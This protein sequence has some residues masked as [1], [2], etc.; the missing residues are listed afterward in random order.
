[1]TTPFEIIGKR[2]VPDVPKGHQRNQREALCFFDDTDVAPILRKKVKPKVDRKEPDP[3][4]VVPPK[5]DKPKDDK[6][7]DDRDVPPILRK[8]AGPKGT[9]KGPESGKGKVEKKEEKIGA[10]KEEKKEERKEE[11]KE[12]RKGK[13]EKK[14][15]D[16]TKLDT[17]EATKAFIKKVE[18]DTEKKPKQENWNFDVPTS[19]VDAA[20]VSRYF[21]ERGWEATVS[22][23]KSSSERV[24]LLAKPAPLVVYPPLEPADE[25]ALFKNELPGGV[26]KRVEETTEPVLAA[27]RPRIDQMF[28]RHN[29]NLLKENAPWSM[30]GSA[31]SA[32]LVHPVVRGGFDI[33]HHRSAP[34]SRLHRVSQYWLE[35]THVTSLDQHGPLRWLF[36]K[37][38]ESLKQ[39]SADLV[40]KDEAT[41]QA[42]LTKKNGSGLQGAD[43]TDFQ[44]LETRRSICNWD[45]WKTPTGARQQLLLA[46]ANAALF[47][48][49]ELA[50][51]QQRA[52]AL[53]DLHNQYPGLSPDF[54]LTSLTEQVREFDQQHQAVRDTL[55]SHY[56][57]RGA[58][59]KKLTNP[60]PRQT[61]ELTWIRKHL[62]LLDVD[63]TSGEWS[64]VNTA[65]DRLDRI[66][67]HRRTGQR[68]HPRCVHAQEEQILSSR[69]EA[70]ENLTDPAGLTSIPA[71][72]ARTVGDLE[73]YTRLT[74]RMFQGDQDALR[75][76][77]A[78]GR[79]N[80]T[81]GDQWELD[82]LQA[83]RD[84]LEPRL[85]QTAEDAK[86]QLK[87]AKRLKKASDASKNL[88]SDKELELLKEHVDAIEK[89]ERVYAALP[90]SAGFW[91]RLGRGLRL[92]T[93]GYGGTVSHLV[94]G[95]LFCLGTQELDRHIARDWFNKPEDSPSWHL[96]HPLYGAAFLAHPK[97]RYKLP[98]TGGALLLNN[99]VEAYLPP[100]RLLGQERAE[101]LDRWMQPGKTESALMA[102]AFL[103]PAK[104]PRINYGLMAAAWGTGRVINTFDEPP[105]HKKKLAAF[106]ALNEDAS[107]RTSASMLEAIAKA[108]DLGLEATDFYRRDLWQVARVGSPKVTAVA[109]RPK[110]PDR[111]DLPRVASRPGS[112]GLPRTIPDHQELAFQR[113][114]VVFNAAFGE[115]LLAEGSPIPEQSKPD[116]LFRKDKYDI[117]GVA[118]EA[119]VTARDAVDF[120]IRE[121]IKR[122]GKK[123]QGSTVAAAAEVKALQAVRAKINEVIDKQILVEH[124]DLKDRML[125]ELVTRVALM[126]GDVDKLIDGK[127]GLKQKIG[128]YAPSADQVDSKFLAKLYRDLAFVHLARA[129]YKAGYLSGIGRGSGGAP[130]QADVYLN[131]L[132][133]ERKAENY[134]GTGCAKD[135]LARAKK[136]DPDNPDLLILESL[137]KDIEKKAKDAVKK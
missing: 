6:V 32:R 56:K 99:T 31:V 84:A 109:G 62:E 57:A 60:Q 120:A 59:L 42:L 43:L 24:L 67:Q 10:P 80:F 27:A 72:L 108:K 101:R 7:D 102:G 66:A 35:N 18:T 20:V 134:L 63:N 116:Y 55:V 136:F 85:W 12:P 112:P 77:Q 125:R 64:D 94:K 100:A 9:P 44:R 29:P 105:N 75:R 49:R 135:A 86:D 124:R 119:L 39:R 131:G 130:G 70:F 118:H 91:R 121:T 28:A 73:R 11:K 115:L 68:L 58:K 127:D 54:E 133:R 74:D 111:P 51:L 33:A 1:M 126:D 89:F 23:G 52:T 48:S 40:S 50:A 34:G 76:L 122:D 95:G 103:Y 38:F 87:K 45:N 97:Y 22:N 110:D 98:I 82:D 113:C 25:A 79:A 15:S 61:A 90:K 104:D 81:T 13:V 71:N 78:K 4:K 83:R 37:K 128:R 30:V 132:E 106:A 41:Y 36:D 69:Q 19:D 92:E 5:V 123:D 16:A 107:T 46:H 137:F 53:E 21:K 8:G 129:A 3:K 17:N 96:G 2:Q 47:N 93:T 88:F 117:G 26:I 65:R 114:M 14:E